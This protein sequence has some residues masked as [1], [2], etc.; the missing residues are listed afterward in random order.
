VQPWW[1]ARQRD[2]ESGAYHP[3]GGAPVNAVGRSWTL[4]GTLDGTARTAVD[5]RGLVAVRPGRWSLDWWIRA[6]EQWVFPS[7]TSGVRQR[8]LDGAPVVETILRAAGGEIVQRVYG[9]RLDAELVV[10]EIENLAEGPVAVAVAVRPYDVQGGGRVESILLQDRTIMVDGHP[11]VL[12]PREPGDLVVASGGTDPA[13]LLGAGTGDRSVRCPAGRA[14]AAVVFPL[15]RG[16]VLRVAIP[17]GGGPAA[18]PASSVTDRLPDAARVARGWGSHATHACRVVLP[19]GLLADGFD[20]SRQALLLAVADGDVEPTPLGPPCR[21]GDDAMVLAALAELGY[22]GAVRDVLLARGHRQDP[23]GAIALGDDDVTASTLVAMERALE[24]HPDDAL[25]VALGEVVADGA[26][27]LLENPE[28]PLTGR[29]LRAA[30]ALLATAGAAEA[31][32]ELEAL[33]GSFED[34]QSA[35]VPDG[36]ELLE[37]RY[38]PLGLDLLG[39]A[40][41]AFAQVGT[42]P[43]GAAQRIERLLALGGPTWA[44]PTFAHPKLG[45]GTGGA[46]HDLRV[47]A[48]VARVIRALLVDDRTDRS[49][50]RLCPHWPLAWL[51]QGAEVHGLPSRHG[52]VSWAVRWHGARPALLWEVADGP[53]DLVVTAPGLDP[54]WTGSGPSG[55]ALLAS[56]DDAP[57]VAEPGGATEPGGGGSFL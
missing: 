52:A 4:V 11:A 43:T 54:S 23:L 44:W 12:L 10:V 26:R 37:E 48:A 13:D 34:P 33:V 32:E 46:G 15:V 42:D 6:E 39:S 36:I 30:V 38:G 19:A 20:A 47:T 16:A 2:P 27:W 9:A 51:G 17:V 31:A 22:D 7:Q 49:V 3:A 25:A 45:T 8:L 41:A 55:E 21:P 28:H 53:A 56:R 24:L 18:D 35:P 57:V 5:R 40:D 14:A 29:A 50:L 1:L